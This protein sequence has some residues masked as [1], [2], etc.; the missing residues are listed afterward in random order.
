[1]YPPIKT[2]EWYIGF[3]IPYVNVYSFWA[4]L[5]IWADLAISIRPSVRMSVCWK[6]ATAQMGWGRAMKFSTFF[7]IKE[8]LNFFSYKRFFLLK[9]RKIDSWRKMSWTK[10]IFY[11]VTFGRALKI[12]QKKL[13]RR[14]RE[15]QIYLQ[16]CLI[17][18]NGQ[19]RFHLTVSD[20]LDNWLF[21]NDLW[22]F[23]KILDKDQF[24]CTPW[25]EESKGI[26]M[27]RI[28]KSCKNCSLRWTRR[29]NS[30]QK[31]SHMVSTV[32]LPRLLSNCTH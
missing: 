12:E 14:I 19:N 28:H 8:I 11:R 18:N 24:L 30:Y 9:M 1:M 4:L 10:K 32:Y 6:Q 7:L 27:R 23:L 21:M 29:M 17:W 15:I 16:H 2:D 20:R 5:R 13:E 25:K 31:C 3:V 26:K 22:A